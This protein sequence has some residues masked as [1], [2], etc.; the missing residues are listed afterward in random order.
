MP[1]WCICNGGDSDYYECHHRH[2]I[3]LMQ[4]EFVGEFKKLMRTV[5]FPNGNLTKLN[6]YNRKMDSKYHKEITS[7]KHF[8]NAWRYVSS[9]QAMCSEKTIIVDGIN[10]ARNESTFHGRK[11]HKSGSRT[12]D[13]K[14][15]Y[16]IAR[17]MIPHC[18]LGM[19]L[20]FPNGFQVQNIKKI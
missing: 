18:L 3:V 16:F 15:H 11:A 7:V 6:K 5:T 10:Q 12:K 1:Y 4:R 8:M 2:C 13:N 9:P 19:A 17:P 14:C 20:Y